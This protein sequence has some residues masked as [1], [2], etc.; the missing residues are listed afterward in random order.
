MDNNCTST[1]ASRRRSLGW[2][3][4]I[5]ALTVLT[6][7][8]GDS[9]LRHQ[10]MQGQVLSAGADEIVVCIGTRDGAE[11]GQVLDVFRHVQ[12]VGQ[13]KSSPFAREP[14]GKVRI[15]DVYDEH[16]A[17]VAIVSGEARTGD[18]VELYK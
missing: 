15:V 7:C 8:A 18:T 6:G 10:F 5:F 13:P 1:T 4:G 3:V 14:V 9:A 2:I 17:H 12:K 11:S 16:Y